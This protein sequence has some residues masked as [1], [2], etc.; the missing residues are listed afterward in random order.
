MARNIPPNPNANKPPPVPVW[1]D[2]TPLNLA[3]PVHALTQNYE[4]PFPIFDQGE[5][6]SVDD[7]LQIF[8][9]NWKN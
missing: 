9:W 3:P 4:K 7:H 2:R 8:F 1:R 6:M 5:G